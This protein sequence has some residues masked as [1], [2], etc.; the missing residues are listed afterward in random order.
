MTLYIVTAYILLT[1]VAGRIAYFH[2]RVADGVEDEGLD[3]FMT[4]AMAMLIGSF[5]PLALPV[6][7]VMWK[8][9][10]TP[11]EIKA[12]RDAMAVRIQELEAELGIRGGDE[13]P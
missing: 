9:A 1:L 7:I 5:W 13:R 11:G 3:R 6:A 4:G 12:E 10:K 2:M 8:P